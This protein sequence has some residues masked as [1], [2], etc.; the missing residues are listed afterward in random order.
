[1]NAMKTEP[2]T[3]LT[4][5]IRTCLAPMGIMAVLMSGS[6]ALAQFS[7][8]DEYVINGYHEPAVD[9]PI[10][11][12]EQAM[13]SGQ[14]TLPYRENGRGMLDALLKA[15][16]I[17]PASQLLVYSPTSL[18]HKLISPEKPR[19]LFFNKNTY[20]GFVQNS[21]IV[22]VTTIDDD[23]GI[24]FYTFDNV[25]ED[26]KGF[27]RSDQT[28]LVC[29]DT[30]GTMGG[31][32]PML[33]A[34][35]SVYSK[36]N[37]PLKNYSGIG[38]IVDQSPVA[39]RWGGWYV[40][41]RHGLQP[42]LGNIF[43]DDASQLENLDD[44]RI[45][46]LETLRDTG[47]MDPEPYPAD[48]SD[49]VALMVLEHQVTIQNQITYVKFKAPAVL[50]RRGIASVENIDTWAELPEEAQGALQRML[51][52]LVAL[53]VFMDAADL[54]SRISG[55]PAYTEAFL[56]RG[57]GD[58][59][60]RSLRELDLGKRLFRYPLSYL[61]YTDDFNS[62]QPYALDYV[63][64]QLA[65]YLSG[66]ITLPG[67]SQFTDAERQAALEILTETLPAFRPYMTARTTAA[68]GNMA[69]A[70]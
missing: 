24:V 8:G 49:I 39:D 30:Q 47:Y 2:K 59:Q 34:L 25:P 40:T 1:M 53:L 16:N 46:N 31:G 23:K 15:L 14:V 70:W 4:A 27:E 11:Q 13:Q 51:D 50:K 9:N 36:R 44:F 45:W 69:S 5:W 62:L 26:S 32:V 22:E 42:H 6:G 21:D 29:H 35:S 17:D 57:V 38:N 33:M 19:A 7:T 12:L 60:G 67:R 61:V 28:C 54:Q 41:G 68:T 18:Q 65:A 66:D 52:K 55:T 10:A 48:T 20:I 43:L 58:S 37:V 56:S 3:G 64:Q 63:L